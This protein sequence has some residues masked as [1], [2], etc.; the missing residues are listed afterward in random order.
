MF[1]YLGWLQ[2]GPQPQGLDG[3]YREQVFSPRV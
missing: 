3:I 2:E 1:D